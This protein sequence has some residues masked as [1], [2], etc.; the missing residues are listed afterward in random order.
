M[1]RETPPALTRWALVIISGP[2]ETI[3]LTLEVDHPPRIIHLGLGD[4]LEVTTPDDPR[5]PGTWSCV[6]PDIKHF[7]WSGERLS[8][9]PKGQGVYHFFALKAIRKGRSKLRME[10]RHSE[11]LK[12]KPDKVVVIKIIVD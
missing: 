3:E 12:G 5:N 9:P 8:P 4:R 1:G 7:E 11:D 6:K 2:V 10:L